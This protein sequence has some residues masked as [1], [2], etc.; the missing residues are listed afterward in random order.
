MCQALTKEVVVVV[1]GAQI[2][3]ELPFGLDMEKR[4]P[5]NA[6]SIPDSSLSVPIRAKLD[7][8]DNGTRIHSEEVVDSWQLD[9]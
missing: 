8:V 3:L 4:S 5:P 6:Q 9:K 2:R 1:L 7:K